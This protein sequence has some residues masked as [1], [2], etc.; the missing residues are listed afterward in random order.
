MEKIATQAMADQAGISIHKMYRSMTRIH[1]LLQNCISR[2]LLNE[3]I[4]NE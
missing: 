1:I 4:H 3:E 2:T